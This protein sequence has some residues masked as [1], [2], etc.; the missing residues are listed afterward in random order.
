MK[1]KNIIFSWLLLSAPCLNTLVSHAASPRAPKISMDTDNTKDVYWSN[2]NGSVFYTVNEHLSQVAKIATELFENDME[3]LTGIK[4][5][6]KSNNA[7]ILIFQLNLLN[8]KEFSMLQKL[9]IPINKLI[10][11]K[12]AFYIGTRGGKV[13]IVG[14]DGRGTAYGILELSHMAGISP[15]NWWNDVKPQPRKLFKMKGGYETLQTPTIEYRGLAIDNP[16]LLKSEK[17]SQIYRLMLRLRANTI[18]VP[19]SKHSPSTNAYK[20]V[21]DSFDLCIGNHNQIMEN[22]LKKNKKSVKKHKHKIQGHTTWIWKDECTWLCSTQPGAIYNDIIGKDAKEG[23][24][25]WVASVRDPKASAYPISLIMD[26]AWSINSIRAVTL[27]EHLEAWLSQ[28]FGHKM[29]KTLLPVMEEYYRLTAIRKPE[30]MGKPYGD[31]EFHSG[32][33]GNELERYLQMYDLLKTKVTTIEKTIPSYLQD[34]YFEMVKYPIFAASCIAEKE[35]EAQEARHIARPGLFDS[36]DEAKT[37]AALSLQAQQKLIDMTYFYNN[38]FAKGKWKDWINTKNEVFKAPQLPGKLT[39]SDIKKYAKGSDDRSNIRP[40]NIINA[41]FEAHDAAIYSDTWGTG[42]LTIPY[43]GHSNRA[44]SLLKGTSIIFNVVFPQSGDARFTIATIPVDAHA[45]TD[46]RVSVSIDHAEPVICN[47]KEAYGSP[48]W[49]LSQ[50][51]G[52]TL[53]SFYLT[54]GKGRHNIEIK[55]LDDQVAIDQWMLDYDVDREYY[56]IPTYGIIQ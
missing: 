44:V 43:L 25:V 35:L 50:H 7:H 26:M 56:I 32:E 27:P 14:S 51:R 21:A 24:N 19:E 6:Q 36:D 4:A 40:L 17:E 37:A 30:H 8:D 31:M 38:K 11:K 42:I 5:K 39:D 55:A 52:Q 20:E 23:H 16:E 33:F 3:T 48:E 28:Q 13:V 45:K 22:E 18:W 1:I 10:T 34:A 2:A 53:R 49:K 41:D 12:E 54:L 47:L 9:R 29:G 15:W 46:M